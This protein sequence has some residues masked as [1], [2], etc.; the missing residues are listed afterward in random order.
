V[1]D[2]LDGS[3]HIRNNGTYFKYVEIDPGLIRRSGVT[4]KI[5]NRPRK[6]Y[7]PPKDHPWRCFKLKGSLSNNI[8]Q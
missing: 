4:K 7:I 2:R 3:M 5:T 8:Y 1:E 6:V